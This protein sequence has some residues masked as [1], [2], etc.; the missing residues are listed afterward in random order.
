MLN[1]SGVQEQSMNMG[2]FTYIE[3]HLRRIMRKVGSKNNTVNYIGREA[4]CGAIGCSEDHKTE[5]IK[6]IDEIKNMLTA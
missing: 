1:S 6:L 3:P 2:A 5:G 4:Q